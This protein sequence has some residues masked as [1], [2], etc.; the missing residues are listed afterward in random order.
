MISDVG[1]VEFDGDGMVVVVIMVMTHRKLVQQMS[2]TTLRF[3]PQKILP[4]VPARAMAF[5]SILLIHEIQS[6]SMS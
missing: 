1:G 5:C 6:E 2:A 3:S 4:R